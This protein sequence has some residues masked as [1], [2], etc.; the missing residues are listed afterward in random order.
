MSNHKATPEQWAQVKQAVDLAQASPQE[1]IVTAETA[2]IL[3]LL[4]RIEA[5]ERAQCQQSAA[6]TLKRQALVALRAVA[7]GAND[8]REQLHDLE[9]IRRALE[10]LP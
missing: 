1:W 8:M 7:T 2:C 9:T 3:E 4:S 5:L 10:Q 6:V